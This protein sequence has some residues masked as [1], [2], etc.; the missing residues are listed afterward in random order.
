[1]TMKRKRI[2]LTAT[3]LLL[4]TFIGCNW[5]GKKNPIQSSPPPS[6]ELIIISDVRVQYI[7]ENSVKITYKT[8]QPAITEIGYGYT[9]YGID[10][11]L[12]SNWIHNIVDASLS[13]EHSI[14]LNNL[15]LDKIYRFGIGIIEPPQPYVASFRG[16]CFR[17]FAT[18]SCPDELKGTGSISGFI[19]PKE[20]Y[21]KV[22]A[23]KDNKCCS[24]IINPE[25]GSYK[26]SNLKEGI[27]DLV[28]SSGE[29]FNYSSNYG[30]YQTIVESNKE[31]NNNIKLTKV[32]ADYLADE[33]FVWFKGDVLKERIDEINKEMGCRVLSAYTS[34]QHVGDSYIPLYVYELLIP[35]EKTVEEMIEIY[36]KKPEVMD[37]EVNDRYDY[38]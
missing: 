18:C 37:A 12:I 33:I 20:S 17:S 16:G 26:I 30:K 35:F 38:I 9:E 2:L 3:F 29:Y 21:A 36:K 22:T 13:T 19:A 25:D 5:F 8:N 15:E 11:Q 4:T 6:S 7:T 31:S 24:T 32:G 14:I 28:V 1:M 27:Y 23:W 10:G 34:G